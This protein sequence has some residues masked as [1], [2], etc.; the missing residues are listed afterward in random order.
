[1]I[2]SGDYNKLKHNCNNQLKKKIFLLGTDHEILAGIMS[3]GTRVLDFGCGDC[4]LFDYLSKKGIK[5]KFTGYD[6]D[7]RYVEIGKNKGYDVY[8]S[9]KSINEK[10]DCITANQVVEHMNLSRLDEFFNQSNNLL[11]ENGKLIIS[12][13]NSDEL[14]TLK[15]IWD[16]PTHVRP[17]SS[18]ALEAAAKQFNF[19]LV[20]TIK[21]HIRVNPIK[22]F[23]NLILGFSIY[24]GIT[25]IFEK[26]HN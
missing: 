18:K 12:T 21:H 7:K 16:D 20:R 9:L 4:S 5:A 25:L 22:I 19:S 17:Y 1:M 14:Y 23:A 11:K 13:L 26:K 8:N 6:T 3:N 10:F 24:S 2:S 15:I